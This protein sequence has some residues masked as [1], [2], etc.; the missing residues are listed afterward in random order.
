MEAVIA[1]GLVQQD[2]WLI[3]VVVTNPTDENILLS[4]DSLLGVVYPYDEEEERKTRKRDSERREEEVIK[5]LLNKIKSARSKDVDGGGREEPTYRTEKA[6]PSA[7]S[8]KKD[9]IRPEEFRASSPKASLKSKDVSELGVSIAPDEG[10]AVT[11]C[12][13]PL[14]EIVGAESVSDQHLSPR[15]PE[16]Q[17]RSPDGVV[18]NQ[19]RGPDSSEK[20]QRTKE[21][22]RV[23]RTV[24]PEKE[25]TGA[26]NPVGEFQ[27]NL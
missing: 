5:H 11:P 19:K 12:Q 22:A 27:R 16:V 15:R 13:R 8:R 21:R 1:R 25:Q 23:A 4:S 3:Q 7:Q 10:V 20:G 14:R 6:T 9:L 17:A 2:K 24:T 26:A 18:E